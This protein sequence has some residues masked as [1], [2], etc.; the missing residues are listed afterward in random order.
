MTPDDERKLDIERPD[1]KP[2]F[3]SI[4]MPLIKR[5]FRVTPVHPLTKQGILRNLHSTVDAAE[6]LSLGERYPNHNVG[7]VSKRGVNRLMFFDD[8]SGIAS[9][10]E[11]DTGQKIPATYRVRTRQLKS[12]TQEL[13][14]R[15]RRRFPGKSF[16][17]MAEWS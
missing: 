10:I 12:P 16:R 2:E 9:R 11:D 7:V 6:V 13:T 14:V 15:L 4:A 5:G 1:S 8:D 3:L 17:V